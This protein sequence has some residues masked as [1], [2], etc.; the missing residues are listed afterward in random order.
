MSWLFKNKKKEPEE[1]VLIILHLN[2]RLMPMDRG[3]IFEDNIDDVLQQNGWGEVCG[4]GTWQNPDG[5]ISGCVVEMDVNRDS[6]DKTVEFLCSIGIIPLLAGA[7]GN[8]TL[9]LW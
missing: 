7:K 4:G 1:N 5:E 8:C 2:A 3:E 9:F 6:V